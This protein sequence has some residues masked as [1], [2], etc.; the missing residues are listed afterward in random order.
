MGRPQNLYIRKYS[1]GDFKLLDP[2]KDL[3][4]YISEKSNRRTSKV[5]RISEKSN[6]GTPKLI[7]PKKSK[8]D[9][10]TYISE[11]LNIYIRKTLMVDFN[12]YIS[13]NSNGD[14]NTYISEKKL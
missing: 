6:G 3:N 5:I 13:E 4:T 8:G 14:L 9:L 7:Y 1:K 12:T 10:K 2:K 11:K